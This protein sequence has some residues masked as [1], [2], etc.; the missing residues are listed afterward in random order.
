MCC[1]SMKS[2]MMPTNEATIKRT[3]VQRYR[4]RYLAAGRT[5]RGEEKAAED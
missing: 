2:L 3:G 4:G 1:V 5:I